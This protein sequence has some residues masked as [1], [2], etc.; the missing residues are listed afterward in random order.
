MG[1][2]LCITNQSKGTHLAF[3]AGTGILNYIDLV[4]RLALGQFSVFPNDQKLHSDFKLVLF[5]SFQSRQDAIALELLEA[6]RDLCKKRGSDCID[7][8]L[9]FSDE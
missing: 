3:A 4:A 6:V 2:G 7:L 9:K 8:T 5:A 1:R